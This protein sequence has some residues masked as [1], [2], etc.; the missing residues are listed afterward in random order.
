MEGEMGINIWNSD[1]AFKTSSFLNIQFSFLG[2]N[3]NNFDGQG[4]NQPVEIDEGDNHVEIVDN[5][6]ADPGPDRN[7]KWII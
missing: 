7:T 1:F 6:E 4:N 2:V 5:D 3:G